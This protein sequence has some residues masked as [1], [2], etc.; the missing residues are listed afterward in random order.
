MWQRIQTVY[1]LIASIS[2][3]VFMVLPSGIA[4]NPANGSEDAIHAYYVKNDTVGAAIAIAVCIL[5]LVCIF[6]FNNRKLQIRLSYIS[7]ALAVVCAALTYYFISQSEENYTF[8]YV[9]GIPLITVLFLLLAIR[10]IRK[11]DALVRS[12][13]RF[14]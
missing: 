3:I 1:L 13:D 5:S 9:I 7:I 6:L 10:S 4:S 14:R 12:M 11:D 2:I 8:N